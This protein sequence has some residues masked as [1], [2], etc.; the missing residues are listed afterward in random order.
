MGININISVTNTEARLIQTG[1]TQ[2]RTFMPNFY[3]GSESFR[4]KFKTL[5]FYDSN[6]GR[7]SKA[8]NENSQGFDI[9]PCKSPRCYVIQLDMH[10]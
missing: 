5:D 8:T 10:M 9:Q 2:S 3:Y 1:S 6:T 7:L 4:W